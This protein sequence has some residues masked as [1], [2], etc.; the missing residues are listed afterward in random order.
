MVLVTRRDLSPGY[1]SVQPAHALAEFATVY[2]KIFGHWHKEHKNLIILS[3]ANELALLDLFK[4]AQDR[5][6]KGVLF[7]EPDI[8]DEATAI[9]LEPSDETYRLTSSLPLALKEYKGD[10]QQTVGG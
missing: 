6:I 10:L 5:G 3:V 4:Q 9:A 1:Q 2:P 8:D 7:R